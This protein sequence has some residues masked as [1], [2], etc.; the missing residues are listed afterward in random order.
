MNW[1]WIHP[2]EPAF[3]VAL[4]FVIIVGVILRVGVP[5]M[6]ARQLDDRAKGIADEIAEARRLREEAQELL[7]SFQRKQQEAEAEAEAIIEQA[8]AEA[9]VLQ[10]Q[11]R[12]DLV[13]RLERRTALAEQRIAQAETQAA[14]DVRA[15][16]AEMAADAAETLLKTGLKKADLNKLVDA[17]IK[18]VGK[19]LN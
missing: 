2:D 7:A 5:G 8:K 4:A 12:A 10:K 19:R 3:Y 1:E 14:A 17:D 11:A 13:E 16:A 9:K 18:L 15:A 6:V